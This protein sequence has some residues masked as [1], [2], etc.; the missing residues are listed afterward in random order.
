MKTI[1]EY[2][3][4]IFSRILQS[5][6]RRKSFL[7]FWTLQ[8]TLT[9]LEVTVGFWLM[10]DTGFLP[11]SWQFWIVFGPIFLAGELAVRVLSPRCG[12]EIY[13]KH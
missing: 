5:T 3:P 4:L 9:V 13:E 8:R 6:E 10:A 1:T 2:R 7:D 12:E 11:W